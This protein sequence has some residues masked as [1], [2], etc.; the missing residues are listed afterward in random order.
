MKT[1]LMEF[2]GT[3]EAST[4]QKPTI[5]AIDD[6]NDNLVLIGCA[7]EV[8]NCEFIGETSGQAALAIAIERQPSLIL[9]DVIMPDMHGID[10]IRRLKQHH[11]ACQIPV[12]AI[13]GLATPEDRQELLAEGFAD[14][15]SKPYMVDDLESIVR[16]HL[17]VEL[18]YCED[19]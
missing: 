12:I 2:S 8:L 5:L 7:L 1:Y 3:C 13:T 19:A 16:R 6:D 10:F 18:L 4:Y 9:L 14:Y 15:L 11:L 17:Q